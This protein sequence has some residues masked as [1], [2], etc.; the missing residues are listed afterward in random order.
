MWWHR[1]RK[2]APEEAAD[3]EQLR[4]DLLQAHDSVVVA[5]KR[6][7]GEQTPA[8]DQPLLELTISRPHHLA[9]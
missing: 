6:I 7:T 9:G 5:K 3:K 2:S 8:G 1:R 4:K